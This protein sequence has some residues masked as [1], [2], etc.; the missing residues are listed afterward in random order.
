MKESDFIGLGALVVSIVAVILSYMAWRVAK[1]S[2]EINRHGYKR[3]IY[4]AFLHLRMHMMSKGRTAQLEEVGKFYVH[5]ANLNIYFEK[6]LATAVVNYY[7]IC[8]RIADL[9]RITHRSP[10]ENNELI[11]LLP[12][13][14]ALNQIIEDKLI[15]NLSLV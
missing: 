1:K 9:A 4:T 12:Q 7:D 15:K 13:E 6:A 3:E 11:A 2:N 8:F 5:L 10:E 14:Q